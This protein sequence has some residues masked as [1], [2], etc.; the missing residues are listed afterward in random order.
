MVAEHLG[1]SIFQIPDVLGQPL[2]LCME[3]GVL[4]ELDRWLMAVDELAVD[5][6]AASNGRDAADIHVGQRLMDSLPSPVDVAAA[7]LG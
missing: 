2:I 5:P 4:G 1:E 3:V 7:G 6:S